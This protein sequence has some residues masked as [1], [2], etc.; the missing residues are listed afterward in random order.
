[1]SLDIYL[2]E[3][4]KEAGIIKIAEADKE[5][6][7]RIAAHGFMDKLASVS[8]VED[9]EGEEEKI[10]GA[11]GKT[12]AKYV[13]GGTAVAGAGAIAGHQLGKGQ[14]KEKDVKTMRSILRYL[15]AS[16]RLK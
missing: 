10:A 1:M 3:L 16:G 9:V 5:A 8:G 2:G 6:Y 14:Q 7:G 15:K 13:A 11:S 4:Q 12:I